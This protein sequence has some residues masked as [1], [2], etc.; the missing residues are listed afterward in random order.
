MSG[1]RKEDAVNKDTL[2]SSSP[3]AVEEIRET[4]ALENLI[5]EETKR[6]LEAAWTAQRRLAQACFT[7]TSVRK[8]KPEAK[9]D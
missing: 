4:E 6:H 5:R 8:E 9:K 7:D 2:S 1:D 3:L